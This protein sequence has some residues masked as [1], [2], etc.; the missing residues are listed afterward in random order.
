MDDIVTIEINYDSNCICFSLFSCTGWEA[1]NTIW[2][3][4]NKH[5]SALVLAKLLAKQDLSWK[6]SYKAEEDS[7]ISLG[8]G[9]GA[10]KGPQNSKEGSKATTSEKSETLLEIPLLLAAREGIVEIFDEILNEYPQAIDHVSENGHNVLHLAIMHRQHKIFERIEKM[11][12]SIQKLASK[13]DNNGNTILHQVAETK[14]YE[15]GKR[16]GPAFQLQE[17]LHWFQVEPSSLKLYIYIHFFL[18]IS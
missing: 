11:E 3:E 5:E 1:I 16:P 2:K 12:M 18:S 6:H 10:D 7:T 14:H 13:I 15:G 9:K 8:L 4:K 17:E